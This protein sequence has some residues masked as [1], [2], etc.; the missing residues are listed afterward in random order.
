MS[1]VA[2]VAVAVRAI[3]G[4]F[5]S[6]LASLLYKQYS[7]EAKSLV[8]VYSWLSANKLSLNIDKTNFI[9]FHPPQKIPHYQVNLQ[10]NNKQIKQEESIKYLGIYIDS[11]LRW[12][13]H[14]SHISKKIKQCIGIISNIRY[15]VSTKFLT[16]LYYTLI[17]PFLTYILT[18]WGNTYP[19]SLKP[20]VTLQKKVVRIITFSSYNDHSSPLFRKVDI[21]K[22]CDLVYIHNALFM[23][24]YYSR[25]LPSV[26][27]NFFK[28]LNKVHQ[29]NTRLACKKSLYLPSIRTNYGK[30]NICYTGVKVW[31]SIND[32][33]K[34]QN[35][36]FLKRLLK[37][38][39]LQLY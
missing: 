4:K 33:L 17:Y 22:F 5:T 18:A 24:D 34:S 7:N 2:F 35:R 27:N 1:L 38:S 32:I 26:F 3:K 28:S 39:L 25:K 10:I 14:I 31:N 12:K 16:Q 6:D 8:N 30:Y 20:L 15:F 11:N 19:S 23:Y 13:H 9:I 36:I 37:E 29:Y 21:L